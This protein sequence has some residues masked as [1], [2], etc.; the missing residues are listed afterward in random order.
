[1]N[2]L[3]EKSISKLNL[4]R[5]WIGKENYLQLHKFHGGGSFMFQLLAQGM[6]HMP[7]DKIITYSLLYTAFCTFSIL[8]MLILIE[9][10]MNELKS[11][12]LQI[13]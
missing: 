10:Y 2:T 7:Q 13:R 3:M 6:I 11:L 1:M 4:K 5:K 9:I 8:A 12:K